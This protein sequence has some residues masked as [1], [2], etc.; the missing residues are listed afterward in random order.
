MSAVAGPVH[1]PSRC[2]TAA[3]AV[4]HD[5][6]RSPHGRAMRADAEAIVEREVP[7]DMPGPVERIMHELG[8]T[9]P[10][11]LNRAMEVDQEGEKLVREAAAQQ[12]SARSDRSVSWNPSR[13]VGTAELI[14]HLLPSAGDLNAAAELLS[15]PQRV[16]QQE[17]E[18]E[19]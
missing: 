1:A 18:I 10:E 8:V 16:I 5:I 19:P 13:S 9:S 4:L 2:L 17:I 11:L 15:M 7:R 6:D 12:G 3:R 14:N